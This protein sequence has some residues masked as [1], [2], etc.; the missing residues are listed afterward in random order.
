MVSPTELP[1][2]PKLLNC[3]QGTP[4]LDRHKTASRVGIFYTDIHITSL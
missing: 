4:Q 3:Q 1:F 2:L